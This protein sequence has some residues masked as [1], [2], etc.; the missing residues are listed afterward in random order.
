MLCA[1]DS[2]APNTW[3]CQQAVRT[4]TRFTCHAGSG[5]LIATVHRSGGRPWTEGRPWTAACAAFQQTAC[6]RAISAA[7]WW[8]RLTCPLHTSNV[9][10]DGVSQSPSQARNH[11]RGCA[12]GMCG[13]LHGPAHTAQHRVSV[14]R[15][16]AAE[17]G[18]SRRGRTTSYRR[19]P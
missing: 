8:H 14:F 12:S 19:R 13:W 4:E 2:A 7:V 10:W 17:L 11:G 3:T 5:G 9:R 16:L 1:S 18:T 15:K 6:Y